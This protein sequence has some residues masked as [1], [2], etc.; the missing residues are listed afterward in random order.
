M[1]ARASQ[2]RGKMLD[3]QIEIVVKERTN[4]QT[5]KQTNTK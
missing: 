3:E 2:D 4:K 5:N 1:K